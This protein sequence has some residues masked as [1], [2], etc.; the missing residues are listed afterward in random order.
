MR[1]FTP[2]RVLKAYAHIEMLPLT[3]GFYFRRY[4]T[5]TAPLPQ[6]LPPDCACPLVAVVWHEQGQSPAISAIDTGRPW[7]GNYVRLASL[8]GYSVAYTVGIGHGFDYASTGEEGVFYQ[9]GVGR[10]AGERRSEAATLH[11][12]RAGMRCGFGIHRALKLNYGKNLMVYENGG[13]HP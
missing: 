3:G 10:I 4:H 2:K 7:K 13:L 6:P 9:E 8:L 11:S 1:P 12:F 5:V